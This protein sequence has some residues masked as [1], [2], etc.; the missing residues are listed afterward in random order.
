MRA[1]SLLLGF[2]IVIFVTV[3]LTKL[4]GDSAKQLEDTKKEAVSKKTEKEKQIA[5]PEGK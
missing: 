3:G 5:T 2:A 4:G 1:M